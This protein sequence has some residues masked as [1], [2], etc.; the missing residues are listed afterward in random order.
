MKVNGSRA[1]WLASCRCCLS[2]A[3]S[4]IA[5][6]LS[7]LL[8]PG[9]SAGCAGAG[10][11]TPARSAA[12]IDSTSRCATPDVYVEDS[13]HWRQGYQPMTDAIE[14][15]CHH[16]ARSAPQWQEALSAVLTEW[17]SDIDLADG[18]LYRFGCH[19]FDEGRARIF[20]AC[21]HWCSIASA[22][23]F[24]LAIWR[25]PTTVKALGIRERVIVS[26]LSTEQYCANHAEEASYWRDRMADYRHVALPAARGA[27]CCMQPPRVINK[28]DAVAANRG[29]TCLQCENRRM[30][31]GVCR[32]HA[33]SLV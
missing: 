7:E 13:S 15:R 27:S 22:G 30:F 26:G 12:R 25:T 3:G 9:V 1:Y 29:F 5:H 33:R 21:H 16:V 20:C 10:R 19:G 17:Q 4:L 18:P 31:A 14:L 11:R 8:E 2:N 28:S 6:S 32:R 24:W 23:A